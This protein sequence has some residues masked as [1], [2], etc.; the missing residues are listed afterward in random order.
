VLPLTAVKHS[1]NQVLAQAPEQNNRMKH[2]TRTK[3]AKRISVG[4]VLQLAD[5]LGVQSGMVETAISPRSGMTKTDAYT[6]LNSVHRDLK[7]AFQNDNAAF[8]RWMKQPNEALDN[9]TPAELLQE[10]RIDVLERVRDAITSLS[11]G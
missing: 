9:K 10:G 2:Q 11:F 6:R 3:K 4:Q 7:R 8:Q 1:S 5:K